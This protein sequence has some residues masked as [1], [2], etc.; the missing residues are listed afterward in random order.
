MEQVGLLASFSKESGRRAGI[1]YTACY[2]RDQ[3]RGEAFAEEWGAQK[4]YTD[5]AQMAADEEIDAVY[6]ASPN[7]LH[8]EQSKLFLQHGKHV[9]CEK[10]ITVEPEELQELRKL[11]QQKNLIYIEALIG[12]YLPQMKVLQ[13]AVERLGPVHLARFDFSQYSSKYPA[14]LRGELPNIFN[15][16]MATGGWMDL[17]IYCLYPAIML[18]GV[19]DHVH[20]H[21]RFCAPGRRQ[22][23]RDL[24]V[25]RQDGGADLLQDRA[26]DNRLGDTGRGWRHPHPAHLQ[27][28]QHD[29][30]AGGRAGD[31]A[32]RAAGKVSADGL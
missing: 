2:S 3:Q 17:G 9:I 24:A 10:P 11:A 19:P 8:Y 5:L 29:P 15:P 22:R 20:A 30:D 12:V 21:A 27:A 23:L 16:Q 28:D 7:R 14:Y 31:A 6:I 1:C 13:G 25:S 18:F 4:V 26:G 32:E